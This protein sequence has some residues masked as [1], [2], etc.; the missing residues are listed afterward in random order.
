MKKWF[1]FHFLQTSTR[2]M[3]IET[4]E[5][6]QVKQQLFALSKLR[7]GLYGGSMLPQLYI[8]PSCMHDAKFFNV[9]SHLHCDGNMST[10]YRDVEYFS[11]MS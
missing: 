5:F 11:C 6:R 4:L 1:P 3:E 7:N 9:D 10:K 2:K 8:C